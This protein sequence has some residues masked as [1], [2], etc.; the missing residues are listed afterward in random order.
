MFFILFGYKR[1]FDKRYFDNCGEEL[2]KRFIKE[3]PEYK[4]YLEHY[5]IVANMQEINNKFFKILQKLRKKGH[6]L[7]LA[8][9]VGRETLLKSLDQTFNKDLAEAMEVF[10]GYIIAYEDETTNTIIS[11]PQKEFFLHVIRSL[12]KYYHEELAENM[13]NTIFIDDNPFNIKIANNFNIK[14]ILYE[15]PQKL[16]QDLKKIEIYT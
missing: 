16:I 7:L 12:Q 5:Y 1:F 14:S 2:I 10:N 6:I 11:K 4:D 8:S 9:N 13:E 3:Y 15:N